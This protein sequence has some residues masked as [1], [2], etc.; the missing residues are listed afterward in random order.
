MEPEEINEF[1]NQMKEGGENSMKSVS[2]VISV[3]AVLV[4]LVTVLGHRTHTEAT[5]MQTRAADKWN[6][7][8]A[9]V[10][11]G[12]VTQRADD[13]LT[14]QPSSDAPKVEK[15]LDAYKA[16]LEKTKASGDKEMEQAKDFESETDLAEQKAMRFDI[17]EAL[18]QISV[19]M[20][21][22]TLLT[23]RPHYVVAASVLGA[24]G[25]VVAASAFLVH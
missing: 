1:S 21:S 22:I 3:L 14:L 24:C 6:Q 23:R 13:L 8:Q 10:I 2:L 9:H 16:D 18:L 25:L 19:V 7:Y 12:L 5:L 4:A 20:A 11:R 17:G 15:Q